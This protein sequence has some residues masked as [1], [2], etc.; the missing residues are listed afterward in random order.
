MQDIKFGAIFK[1]DTFEIEA[2]DFLLEPLARFICVGTAPVGGPGRARV[3]HTGA[4]HA[5]LGGG[6]GMIDVTASCFF[7]TF[8]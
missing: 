1:S 8:Y 6:N 5:S 4:G 2:T 7:R 3:S